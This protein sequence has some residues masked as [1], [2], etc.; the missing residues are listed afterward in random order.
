MKNLSKNVLLLS[1]ALN[2]AACTGGG[3]FGDDSAHWGNHKC[4]AVNQKT[5][6]SYQGWSTNDE[7]AKASAMHKC[8]SGASSAEQCHVTSCANEA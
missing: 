5:G 1:A 2:L 6:K 4:Q 8:E 7:D 3:F